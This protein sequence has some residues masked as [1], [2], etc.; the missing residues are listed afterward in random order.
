[1]MKVKNNLRQIALLFL[2]SFGCSSWIACADRADEDSQTIKKEG[3]TLIFKCNDPAFSQDINQKLID[4]FFK[5]YPELVKTYNSK[6]PEVV[7]FTIDPAYDGV[8]A[9]SNDRVVFGARYMSSHPGDIDVVTHEVMHIVQ[10][11][12]DQSGMPGWL[13]EGIA[14]YVRYVF[15]V[16]NEGAGWKLP[17]YSEN[18]NYRNSYRISARF[19]VWLEHSGYEGIVKKLDQAGRDK[20]YRDGEIWRKLTGKTVDELWSD[21]S[22]SPGL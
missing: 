21:Y 16:D 12:G 8:A 1:M 6:S 15:G 18:Q 22:G 20:T 5:V 19:L 9:T 3:Y 11:Y 2:V 17:D 4:T 10:A 13:T 14:D 7:W